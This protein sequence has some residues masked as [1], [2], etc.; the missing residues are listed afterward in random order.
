MEI[1]PRPIRSEEEADVIQEHMNTLLGKTRTE[2]EEDFL[3]LLGSLMFLWED[4][5]YDL[6]SAEPHEMVRV[7]I[8]DNGLRQK[9]LVGPVFPT[10]SIA[11]EVLAGKRNLTYDFV[12]RLSQYFHVP[13]GAF[14]KK[15]G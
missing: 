2:D 6:S 8:E 3:E 9:D 12:H 14:F 7:L 11:S 15:S 10:E 13:A 1:V 5:R 4:G